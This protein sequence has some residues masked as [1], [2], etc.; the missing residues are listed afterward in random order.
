MKKITVFLQI[1][2]LLTF[3]PIVASAGTT[4]LINPN[5]TTLNGAEFKDLDDIGNKYVRISN[6]IYNVNKNIFGTGMALANPLGYPNGKSI[7]KQFPN[8]TFQLIEPGSDAV[9]TWRAN[10]YKYKIYHDSVGSFEFREKADE[11]SKFLKERDNYLGREVKVLRKLEKLTGIKSDSLWGGRPDILL[12]KYD[13]NNN[14]VSILI[15]EVKYTQDTGYAIQ[16]LKELLEYMALI[17]SL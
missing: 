12:E 5:E 11:I 15:G 4:F 2:F 14:L 9:A 10:S 13:E 6:D 17:K 8:P 1:I 7:I 16:G 3:F